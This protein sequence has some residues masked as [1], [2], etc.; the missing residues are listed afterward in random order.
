M[1][2]RVVS[3]V[4]VGRGDELMTLGEAFGATPSTVLIG[5][6]AGVGKSRLIQEFT[7][8][9]ADPGRVLTGGC[10]EVGGVPY[11]PFTAALRPLVRQLGADG[12]AALLPGGAPGELSR[13]LPDLGGCEPSADPDMARA[14]LFEQLLTLL[15]RLGEADGRPVA[16]IIEDAHW[17]DPASRDLISFLIRN[18]QTAPASLIAI[19]YRSDELER[20]HPLRHLLAELDRLPWV[21]RLDLPRL[22]KREVAAQAR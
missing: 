8:S 18:Q 7:G 15:E 6:E 20:T 16:L 17:A 1:S 14:R 10:V 22:R 13:L 5:G 21:T 2:A 3:P 11:A 9:V 19:T 12:V 4:L